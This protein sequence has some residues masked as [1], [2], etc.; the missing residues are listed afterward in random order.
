MRDNAHS[1]RYHLAALEA[2]QELP[3]LT[4]TSRGGRISRALAGVPSQATG[5][6]DFDRTW[7]ATA[8]DQRK[9]RTLLDDGFRAR[10]MDFHGELHGL[11]TRGQT[12]IVWRTSRQLPEDIEPMFEKAAEILR[13]LERRG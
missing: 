2:V 12:L 5:E 4:M 1:H 3:P 10:L 11:A 9:L 6:A 8:Q 13:R 7:W